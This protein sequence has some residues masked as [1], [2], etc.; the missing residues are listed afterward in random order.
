MADSRGFKPINQLWSVASGVAS[1]DID[2]ECL[3]EDISSL[4]GPQ[5]SEDQCPRIIPHRGLEQQQQQQQQRVRR[6]RRKEDARTTSSSTLRRKN[7]S[8][9]HHHHQHHHPPPSH[10]HHH[11]PQIN[12]N[13]IDN[14]SRVEGEKYGVRGSYGESGPH[15]AFDAGSTTLKLTRGRKVS[16]RYLQ[17]T[18]TTTTTTY[19]H[20][21][22]IPRFSSRPTRHHFA[23]SPF[24]NET[25]EEVQED[26]EATLR[27]L[28]V[29]YD[30]NPP[31]FFSFS[32]TFF[33]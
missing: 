26:D 32:P 23:R 1:S 27:E 16:S 30:K 2:S 12:N 21:G 20:G 22:R 28:L 17:T 3:Y 8:T 9:N 5:D 6:S 24:S 4:S 33:F 29:R 13:N 18:T 11:N 19:H 10:Q 14:V 25:Q 31:L 15:A 7:Q